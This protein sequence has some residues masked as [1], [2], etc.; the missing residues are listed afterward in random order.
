MFLLVNL[1]GELTGLK[2]MITNT[3]FNYKLIKPF[4]RLKIIIW[5]SKKIHLRLFKISCG[6]IHELVFEIREEF[7]CRL[8]SRNVTFV[9]K[10]FSIQLTIEKY[11]KK[12]KNPC[13]KCKSKDTQR[14]F[15]SVS[16]VTSKKS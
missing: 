2:I 8:M 16:V 7:T 5:I 3:K 13:H 6:C 4:A 9:K 14:L 1:E 10:T 12:P 15:S 11:V